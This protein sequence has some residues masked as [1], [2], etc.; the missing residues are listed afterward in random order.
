MFTLSV[1]AERASAVIMLH[2]IVSQS[3]LCVCTEVCVTLYVDAEMQSC[4]QMCFTQRSLQTE[5][6]LDASGVFV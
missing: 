2:Y 1:G 4:F 3:Q 5:Q 6:F